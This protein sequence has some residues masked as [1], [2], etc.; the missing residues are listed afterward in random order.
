MSELLNLAPPPSHIGSESTHTLPNTV[1]I[2]TKLVKADF[3]GSI[4]TGKRHLKSS[5]IRLKIYVI[6]VM[7]LVMQSKN[8]CLVGLSGIVIHETENTFKLITA[9]NKLKR[10]LTL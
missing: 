7:T 3:H 5:V 6:H 4:I 10:M 2:H 8:A 1:G 9:N